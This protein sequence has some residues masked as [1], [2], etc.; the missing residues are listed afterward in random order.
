MSD[1]KQVLYLTVVL[2]LLRLAQTLAL[3][4]FGLV[5]VRYI[6]QAAVALAG[7]ETSLNLSFSLVVQLYVLPWVG[8]ALMTWLWRRERHLRRTTVNR[9][10][11]RNVAL[12]IK[13]DAE[14]T[15]SGLNE[16]DE[17]G[18]AAKEEDT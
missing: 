13:L 8:M 6:S 1:A 12:E 15:S 5:A 2:R 11:K 14:R 17:A 9:E 7:E 3:A 16:V 18:I 4:G 10:N